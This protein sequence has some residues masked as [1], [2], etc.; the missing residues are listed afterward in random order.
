MSVAGTE[1]DHR[2]PVIDPISPKQVMYRLNLVSVLRLSED[3]RVRRHAVF[4][5]L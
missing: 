5:A 2:V 4:L 1:D 3:Q